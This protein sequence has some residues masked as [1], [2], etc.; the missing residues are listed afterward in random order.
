MPGPRGRGPVQSEA[1]S[2][3]PGGRD[4]SSVGA[5]C[6]LWVC[7]SP[8]L[9]P[10]ASDKQ[11]GRKAL[12]PGPVPYLACGFGASCW[13]G[14]GE[15]SGR[16][17]QLWIGLLPAPGAHCSDSAA[18]LAPWSDTQP[19][20][21][22][23]LG[24]KGHIWGQA[25]QVHDHFCVA[26]SSA[27]SCLQRPESESST[28]G[29]ALCSQLKG[30][31]GPELEAEPRPVPCTLYPVCEG[32]PQATIGMATLS[33]PETD[34]PSDMYSHSDGH[35]SSQR[36]K[37]LSSAKVESP[38]V[39]RQRFWNFEI[40]ESTY[41]FTD[42]THTSVEMQSRS[43]PPTDSFWNLPSVCHPGGCYHPS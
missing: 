36:S 7:P 19:Q 1:F 28:Q 2:W 9:P 13:G 35:M 18:P 23:V 37:P 38:W 17:A 4:G 15:G 39:R 43:M 3:L 11:R 30:Q 26:F 6:S 8:F 10:A 16:G 20:A 29:G 22:V 34:D 31:S 25:N 12:T 41:S 33:H 32:K 27:A 5:S 40:S 21:C 42:S 24:C 14:G